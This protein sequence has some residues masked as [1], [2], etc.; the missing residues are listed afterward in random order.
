MLASGHW[1]WRILA[2]GSRHRSCRPDLRRL[3]ADPA[4]SARGVGRVG[5]GGAT[6]HSALSPGWTGCQSDRADVD[7]LS[8][9][10][11]AAGDSTN[12]SGSIRD[13]EKARGVAASVR[14]AGAG[15]RLSGGGVWVAVADLAEHA[16]YGGVARG[17][18]SSRTDIAAVV[19]GF[20]IRM[21]SAG[22][23]ARK[24][25]D[26]STPQAPTQARA[27]SDSAAAW[28]DFG[29]AA[30]GLRKTVLTLGVE[31]RR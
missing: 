7:P 1:L 23:E 31:R 22:A 20:G 2:D 5:V 12:G 4:R 8:R 9:R 17:R 29:G 3:A 6:R 13:G 26:N 25:Q 16:G 15:L 19:P 21:A 27:V 11:V 18:T 14:L 10:S 28:G 30:A 24:D